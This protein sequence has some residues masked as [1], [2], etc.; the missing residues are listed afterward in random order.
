MAFTGGTFPDLCEE[1]LPGRKVAVSLTTACVSS[2]HVR[3]KHERTCVR[4]VH[5]SS[6]PSVRARARC[7]TPL[8]QARLHASQ[9]PHGVYTHVGPAGDSS[10]SRMASSS[11]VAVT[12]PPLE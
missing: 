4:C 1:N 2:S 7:V 12:R 3:P 6:G 9:A 8:P 11:C 5:V 10:S